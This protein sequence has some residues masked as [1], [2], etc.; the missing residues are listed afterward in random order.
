VKAVHKRKTPA[1]ALLPAGV[2]FASVTRPYPEEFQDLTPRPEV[3]KKWAE[4]GGGKFS[5]GAEDLWSPGKDVVVT[6]VGRQNDFILLAI[7]LFLLDL[8]IRRVRLFDRKFRASAL[9]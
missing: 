6:R 8:L 2:S 3:L 5:P 4:S 7:V 1:G 9:P